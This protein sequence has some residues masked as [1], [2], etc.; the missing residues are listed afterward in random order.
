MHFSPLFIKAVW[1]QKFEYSI[2]GGSPFS[3]DNGKEEW[4]EDLCEGCWEEKGG[5]KLRC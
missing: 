4:G 3:K 1:I 2:G 5:L